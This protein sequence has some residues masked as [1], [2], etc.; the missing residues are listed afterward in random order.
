MLGST[1]DTDAWLTFQGTVPS[2][3]N[4]DVP[5]TLLPL[6][7]EVKGSE[8]PG[9]L[10]LFSSS[11]SKTCLGMVPHCGHPLRA[12]W[13]QQIGCMILRPLALCEAHQSH[14]YLSKGKSLKGFE[15]MVWLS[16]FDARYSIRSPD[17]SS[18]TLQAVW[19]AYPKPSSWKRPCDHW[20]QA[21]S[22]Q[23]S[24]SRAT[25]FAELVSTTQLHLLEART[26]W[27]PPRGHLIGISRGTLHV[28]SE[29][30]M[31]TLRRAQRVH[32]LAPHRLNHV[33][34]QGAALLIAKTEQKDSLW[35][36]AVLFWGTRWRQHRVTSG[37]FLRIAPGAKGW[38]TRITCS[39]HPMFHIVP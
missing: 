30:Q 9:P 18:G 37:F 8:V 10:L 21:G 11:T 16:C 24:F 2:S 32:K 35:E 20:T 39:L 4:T 26:R 31:M 17:I 33:N 34:L 13:P 25:L 6:W 29:A 28:I 7:M 14:L 23:F 36:P 1:D 19:S 22:K 15:R 27:T 5:A 12:R 38:L 3:A